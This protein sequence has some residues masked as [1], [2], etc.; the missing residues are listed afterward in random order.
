[1]N[2]WVSIPE[3][4]RERPCSHHYQTETAVMALY[5][6]ACTSCV[7][8][9][10][11]TD[12]LQCIWFSKFRKEVHRGFTG[13]HL[14]KRQSIW[15]NIMGNQFSRVLLLQL[16][17]LVRY[18]FSFMLWLMVMT[19]WRELAACINTR[20]EYG[21]LPT[22]LVTVDNPTRDKQLFHDAFPLLKQNNFNLMH[23]YA[24]MMTS[25]TFPSP[26]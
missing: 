7:F 11:T 16:T 17:N 19:T 14:I 8:T 5:Q 22:E 9:N 23:Y 21:Q 25:M 1:M 6:V 18:G 4:E 24:W 20:A 15:C 13:I 3:R 10:C 12:P 26:K 2:S